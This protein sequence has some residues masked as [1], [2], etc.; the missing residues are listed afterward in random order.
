MPNSN[1]QNF[2]AVYEALTR[3]GLL[4]TDGVIARRLE[5]I[6][7]RYGGQ[8][9]VEELYS[10][11]MLRFRML[12]FRSVTNHYRGVISGDEALSILRNITPL[13]I[14][15]NITE[16]DLLDVGSSLTNRVEGPPLAITGNLSTTLGISTVIHHDLRLSCGV[17]LMRGDHLLSPSA[18]LV[19]EIESSDFW[20]KID[21]PHSLNPFITMKMNGFFNSQAQ[22]SF[23]VSAQHTELEFKFPEIKITSD[24]LG[25]PASIGYSHQGHNLLAFDYKNSF[26]S[27]GSQFTSKYANLL[28]NKKFYPF[29]AIPVEDTSKSNDMYEFLTTK[30]SSPKFALMSLERPLAVKSEFFEEMPEVVRTAG[31]MLTMSNV[32]VNVTISIAVLGVYT[33]VYSLQKNIENKTV[34]KGFTLLQVMLAPFVFHAVSLCFVH[35]LFNVATRKGLY[36]KIRPIRVLLTHADSTAKRQTETLS[37][38]GFNCLPLLNNV[39]SLTTTVLTFISLKKIV[40]FFYNGPTVRSSLY[41]MGSFLLLIVAKRGMYLWT[42]TSSSGALE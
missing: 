20:K 6:V 14:L 31:L 34:K 18:A 26:Y 24:S 11:L 32:L 29:Q 7:A 12:R 37:F 10:A 38:S 39:F 15:R 28:A 16:E 8:F 35:V 22:A 9:S 40:I 4:D 2:F 19:L 25:I 21:K 41:F 27:L 13:S 3:P 1:L 36:Y 23:Q 17:K 5:P 33:Y 30:V 42:F